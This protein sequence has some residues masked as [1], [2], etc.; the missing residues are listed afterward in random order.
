[1]IGPVLAGFENYFR[2]RLRREISKTVPSNKKGEDVRGGVQDSNKKNKGDDQGVEK[3]SS[4]IWRR[5]GGAE[6]RFHLRRGRELG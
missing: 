3:F 1:M 6:Q 4:G 5:A 2:R